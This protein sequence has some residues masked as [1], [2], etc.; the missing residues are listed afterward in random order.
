M[1]TNMTTFTILILSWQYATIC[2]YLFLW[3]HFYFTLSKNLPKGIVI[4]FGKVVCPAGGQ[5]MLVENISANKQNIFR[6]YR[7][8]QNVTI[9]MVIMPSYQNIIRI[10]VANILKYITDPP[11]RRTTF[12]KVMTKVITIPFGKFLLRV[13]SWYK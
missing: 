7:K 11:S 10:C 13:K 4:T 3:I 9:D 5:V 6:Y 8:N 12:P 2:L 1:I